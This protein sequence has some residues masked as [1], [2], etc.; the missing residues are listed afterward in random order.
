LCKGRL[1]VPTGHAVH[2]ASSELKKKCVGHAAQK[3]SN[4]TCSQLFVAAFS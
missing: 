4:S 1:Y 2:P 3:Q